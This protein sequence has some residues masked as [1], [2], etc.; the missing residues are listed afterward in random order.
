MRSIVGLEGGRAAICRAEDGSP[1]LG[2]IDVGR[3]VSCV[4]CGTCSVGKACA[5]GGGTA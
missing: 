5:Q 1:Y 3:A 2:A 4:Q